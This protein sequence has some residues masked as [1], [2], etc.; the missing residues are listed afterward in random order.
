MRLQIFTDGKDP[1]QCQRYSPGPLIIS[2]LV[3]ICRSGDDDATNGPTHLQSCRA[4]TSKRKGN[5]LA[6]I[7]WRIRNEETPWN[8]FESLSNDKNWQ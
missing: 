7:C 4:G 2:V 5:N 8:T 6:S 3:S 1:L